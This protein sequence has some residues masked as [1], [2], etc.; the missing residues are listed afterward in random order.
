MT[1]PYRSAQPCSD[2][3]PE[4][5]CSITGCKATSDEGAFLI[6][7]AW[8]GVILLLCVNHRH[9]AEGFGPQKSPLEWYKPKPFPSEGIGLFSRFLYAVKNLWHNLLNGG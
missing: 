9:L 6:T 8:Q 2:W 1:A 4:A 5:K 3:E 7:E